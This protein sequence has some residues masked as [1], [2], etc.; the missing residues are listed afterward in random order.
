MTVNILEDKDVKN[1]T[2]SISDGGKHKGLTLLV[3]NERKYW[4]GRYTWNGKRPDMRLGV[5]NEQHGLEWARKQFEERVLKPLAKGK[6]P[7]VKGLS[8]KAAA[9]VSGVRTFE[10]YAEDWYGLRSTEWTSEKYKKAVR[11]RFENHLYP[12]FR[13]LPV[14]QISTPMIKELLKKFH[15]KDKKSAKLET[16]DKC[17]EHLVGIF[18]LAMDDTDANDQ[19][20]LVKNPA[21]FDLKNT[22]LQKKKGTLKVSH[23]RMLASDDEGFLATWSALPGFWAEIESYEHRNQS[24]PFVQLGLELLILTMVRPVELRE[25]RWSEFDFDKKLWV[26]PARRMKMA[27]PHLVPLSRQVIQ[28]L[29]KLREVSGE[30]KHLFPKI[31]KNG[32]GLDD[33]GTQSEN[34]LQDAIKRMGYNANPHGFRR[35]AS[36]YLHSQEI[37]EEGEERAMFDSLWV[38]F[39]LAHVDPNKVRKTY[40]EA[41]YLKARRRMLQYYADAVVPNPALKL[42]SKSA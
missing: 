1:A 8:F 5:Y 14:D 20:V 37:G 38:E 29:N 17:K 16:R 12:A 4:V 15:G 28:L 19:P 42:V 39:Q 22:Q 23:R 10:S 40:N 24:P 3:K 36:T 2:R 41:D 11:G 25:A 21:D 33:S 7:K 34:T 13:S 6:D 26:I 31:T 9:N 18:A 27:Y 35:M 32:L 30:C